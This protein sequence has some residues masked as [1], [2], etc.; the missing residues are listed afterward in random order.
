MFPCCYLSG[1]Q[2]LNPDYSVNKEKLLEVYIDRRKKGLDN[3]FTDE[4]CKCECHII[5]KQI[6]H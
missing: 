6:M 1:Y 5:G 4:L 3:D 2:Y